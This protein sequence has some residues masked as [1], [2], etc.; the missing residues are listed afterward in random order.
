MIELDKKGINLYFLPPYSSELNRIKKL[1]Q[2][3]KYMSGCPQNGAYWKCLMLM[4]AII[5]CRILI[6]ISILNFNKCD[7]L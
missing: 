3:M 6:K 7:F 4:S 2:Q 1:W 5:Y